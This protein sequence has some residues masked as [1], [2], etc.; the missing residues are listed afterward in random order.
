MKPKRRFSAL[1]A[2]CLAAALLAVGVLADAAGPAAPVI[3]LSAERNPVQL[4]REGLG[5]ARRSVRAVVYKFDEPGVLE[6]IAAAVGRGVE[7]RLLVD[8]E[9]A[10][11]KKSLV[12]AA[13]AAGAEV[14]EWPGRRGK[15]HAKFTLID[16]TRALTGSFNWTRSALDKNVELVMVFEDA[17][18]L[19]RWSELFDRLWT[20]A[21]APGPD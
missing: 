11:R 20:E 1:G 3:E 17:S 8:G 18:T 19:S 9:Q 15:L 13:A 10:S 7:V 12:G 2:W 4:T 5:A 16:D 14:R 6:S 21:V